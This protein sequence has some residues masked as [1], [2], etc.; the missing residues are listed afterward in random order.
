MASAGN[1][2][3][4]ARV[5]PQGPEAE[6]ALD[7]VCNDESLSN[8]HRSF[9]HADLGPRD[10][11]RD[12][13]SD[14]SS[15]SNRQAPTHNLTGR[16]F[17]LS[18]GQPNI[19]PFFSGWRL[20]RDTAEVD[21]L[22][23]RPGKTKRQVAPVHAR[24]QLHVKSGVPMLFGVDSNKPVVYR[25]HDRPPLLLSNGQGHVLYQRTNSFAVG[26]LQYT[27]EF[28]DFTDELYDRFVAQR[29]ALI[30]SYGFLRPHFGLS[31]VCRHQDT[32][33]GPVITHGTLSTG[34]IW[35][36]L[37]RSHRCVWRTSSCEAASSRYSA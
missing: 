37:R 28:A 35:R 34:K 7:F 36:R 25:V 5:V 13:E 9:I 21:L 17:T 4:L 15:P 19:Q 20:G 2:V 11:L 3:I 23:V 18:L 32:K 6:D 10:R 24:I 33:R 8:R 14:S 27:L 1:A 16:Y 26:Q 30:E 12:S 31:A 22:L 29:N